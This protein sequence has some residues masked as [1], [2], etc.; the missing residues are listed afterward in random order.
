M[1]VLAIIGGALAGFVA[2][3][4]VAQRRPRPVKDADVVL[5]NMAAK[6]A[7]RQ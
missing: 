7:R 3:V 4:L 5:R 2:G 1:I 6:Q